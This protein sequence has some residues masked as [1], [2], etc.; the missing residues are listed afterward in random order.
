VA[1]IF[2]THPRLVGGDLVELT[3]DRPLQP[4]E[5]V[6]PIVRHEVLDHRG[7]EFRQ[8]VNEVSSQMTT[9]G[10]RQLNERV[11]AGMDVSRVARA[12]ISAHDF[13]HE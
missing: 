6:T 12:W 3:D 7:P 8:L 10:L 13:R 4:A 5:T 9:A 1:R 11:A 2:T